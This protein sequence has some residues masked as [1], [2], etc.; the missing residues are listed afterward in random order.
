[1]DTQ[2]IDVVTFD[3]FRVLMFTAFSAALLI[4]KWIT[5]RCTL[6][7]NDESLLG[8]NLNEMRSSI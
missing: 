2:V 7:L 8:E 1:M 4:I 5:L 6:F 3:F